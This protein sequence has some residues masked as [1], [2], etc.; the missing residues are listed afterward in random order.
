M[1]EECKIM[2]LESLAQF[3]GEIL[4]GKNLVALRMEQLQA[5]CQ[6]PDSTEPLSKLD[7]TFRGLHVNLKS[8]VLNA[9]EGREKELAKEMVTYFD[10]FKSGGEWIPMEQAREML[11]KLL[12]FR[13]ALQSLP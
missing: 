9:P 13:T 4:E 8:I 7:D 3:R 11:A 10:Q 2:A 12:E 1:K 5:H 6:N